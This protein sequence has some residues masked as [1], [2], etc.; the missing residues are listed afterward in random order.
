MG[1]VVLVPYMWVRGTLPNQRQ[2][3]GPTAVCAEPLT[4]EEQGI[5]AVFV[6]QCHLGVTIKQRLPTLRLV[7]SVSDVAVASD[8]SCLAYHCDSCWRQQSTTLYAYNMSMLACGLPIFTL[9]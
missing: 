3:F 9:A 6:N 2:L 1:L 7:Y 8:Y 4:E 5:V